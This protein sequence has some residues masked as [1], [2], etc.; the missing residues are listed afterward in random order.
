M[1]I[2][3]IRNLRCQVPKKSNGDIETEW[4][5]TD[6]S[7][8]SDRWAL[9]PVPADSQR[10]LFYIT[11]GVNIQ[12]LTRLLFPL[13]LS[14]NATQFW[15]SLTETTD[16]K[17]WWD[18]LIKMEQGRD[19]ASWVYHP[20]YLISFHLSINVNNVIWSVDRPFFISWYCIL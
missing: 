8:T 13:L 1:I 5:Q 6:E 2:D 16:Y 10:K 9:P 12:S 20:S 3:Q 11:F 17:F 15:C 4:D 18:P 14:V 7:E 19:A